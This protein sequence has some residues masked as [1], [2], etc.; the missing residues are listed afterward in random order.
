MEEKFFKD[1]KL[2]VAIKADVAEEIKGAYCALGW[3]LKEEYD[4]KRYGDLVHMDFTRPHLIAEKDRLQLLQ[5]RL[6][7]AVNFWAEQGYTPARARLPWGC[8]SVFWASR[9][10]CWACSPQ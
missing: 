6:E 8:F 4:D 10:W 3:E 1:D 9:S 2:S 7:V 5:V